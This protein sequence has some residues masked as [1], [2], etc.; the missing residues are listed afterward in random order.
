M[1]SRNNKLQLDLGVSANYLKF[2]RTDAEAT[3][4]PK[5]NY[6]MPGILVGG[7]FSFFEKKNDYLRLNAQATSILGNVTVGPYD[8]HIWEDGEPIEMQSFDEMGLWI[9]EAN[10]FVSYGRK[11]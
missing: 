5:Y 7:S 1:K 6:L 4:P 3:P 9:N 11:F 2:E 10:L 8:G